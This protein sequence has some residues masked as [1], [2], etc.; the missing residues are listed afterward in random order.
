MA[1]STASGNFAGWAVASVTVVPCS[2][3]AARQLGDGTDTDGGVR[4]EQHA[5]VAV[6]L[7]DDGER[8]GVVQT[9]GLELALDELGPLVGFD[10][11]A[12]AGAEVLQLLGG[13]ATVAAVHLEQ[14]PLEVRR[15]LDVHAGAER[16]HHRRGGHVVVVEEPLEDVVRVG[17]DDQLIDRG[18]HPASD[19]AAEHVAEVAAGHAHVDRAGQQIREH[20]VVDDLRHH[21]RPVDAVHRA[22]LHPLAELRIVEHRLDHVLAVVERALDRH[23]AHVRGFHRRHLLALHVAGA[24]VRV[25]DDDVDV[26]TVL[27]AVDRGRAG[28]AAGGTDDRDAGAAST[29]HLVEQAADQLQRD[30]LER[31]RGAV[32]QLL[33]EVLVAHLH[34]RHDGRVSEGGVRLVAQALHGGS[35]QVVADEQLDHL[36][37]ALGVGGIGPARRQR[38]PLL[39]DVQP[40]VGGQAGEQCVGE[41]ED[42]RGARGWRRTARSGP[43]HAQQAADVADDI[44][45]AQL[46]HGCLHGLLLRLVG[47]EDEAG[48]GC[49]ALLLGGA[50]AD[51]VTGE[52]AGDRVQHAGLVGD[53]EAEE[54]LG[55]GLVDRQDRRPAEANRARR[56]CRW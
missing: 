28:V 54:V 42:R 52:H 44:Q 33:H 22:E 2:V 18:A 36:R 31:E 27:D 25:E 55:A 32:E 38:R 21:T 49:V 5:A 6:G 4:V 29:Q 46:A 56:G 11:E 37:G 17:G 48:V 9:G 35:R 50:D 7:R 19:P 47:D 16:G 10:G 24:V 45:L 43:D 13:E 12:A 41:A 20:D 14:Q 23:H 15:H 30:V 3:P 34:Q 53:L 51:V 1:R 8:L 26:G 39:G 40:A